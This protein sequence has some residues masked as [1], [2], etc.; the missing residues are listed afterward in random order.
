MKFTGLM[1]PCALRY[2]NVFNLVDN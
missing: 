1:R 2:V